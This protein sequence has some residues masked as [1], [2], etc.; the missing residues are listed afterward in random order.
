MLEDIIIGI[1]GIVVWQCLTHLLALLSDEDDTVIAIMAYGI[2]GLL[3]GVI[4]LIDSKVRL[5]HDRRK[6]NWYVFYGDVTQSTAWLHVSHFAM[7]PKVAKKYFVRHL[8]EDDEPISYSIKIVTEGK[9]FKSPLS[10]REILTK[11]DILCKGK[12]GYSKDFFKKFAE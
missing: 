10:P 9:D 2:W 12:E 5:F 6:Y 3:H 7:T 8:Q 11:D 4:Y 1:I